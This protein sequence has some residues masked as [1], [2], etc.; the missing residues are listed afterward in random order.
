[1]GL[2]DWLPAVINCVLHEVT[3]V[4]DHVPYFLRV[5]FILDDGQYI[6]DLI[7][8]DNG[9]NTDHHYFDLAYVDRLTSVCA[10]LQ[11]LSPHFTPT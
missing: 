2:L 6:K 7:V 10:W 1:M 4:H 9:V 3:E 11:N 8:R 5:T